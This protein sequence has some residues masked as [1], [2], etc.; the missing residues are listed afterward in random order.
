MKKKY[1]Y[2]NNTA[3]EINWSQMNK[4]PISAVIS[5]GSHRNTKQFKN[6]RIINNKAV[7]AIKVTISLISM[8]LKVN[9]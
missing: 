7:S 1:K 9:V 3:V 5:K 6:N 2:H 8:T 4:I